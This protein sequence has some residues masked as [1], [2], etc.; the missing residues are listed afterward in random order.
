MKRREFVKI[1]PALPGLALACARG[2]S[3]ARGR[4]ASTRRVRPGDPAWPSPDDWDA[5]RRA[6]GGRLTRPESPFVRCGDA[7]SDACREVVGRLRNPYYIGDQAGLTQTSGWADAWRSQPSAYAIAAESTADVVAAV[8]FAREHNLRLVVKGGG[9]SYKGTSSAPDSLLIWTRR[10]NRVV[11]REDF[12]GVGCA[13]AGRVE[14][15]V[16]VEA[17]AMWMPVYQAVSVEAGRYVQGGGCATVG[18]AGLIQSGG[19]GSFSKA[20]GLAATGLLEA[21]VV[22][23][24]GV[25]RIA[26][27]CTHPDLFWA[28]KGGGGGSL[29]VVTKVTLRTHDLPSY[30]GGAFGVIAASSDDAFR[31]LI[32]H[33]VAFYR[34]HLFSPTWGE[35]LVFGPRNRLRI[36]MV[37]QGIDQAAA[38]RVWQQ[39]R[40]WLERSPGKFS[41]EEP[42][43][44][45]AVPA[46]HFW[47]A[48]FLE[49]NAPGFVVADDRP[50]AN[51]HHVFWA[52]DQG[53]AGQFLHAYRTAWLPASLLESDM[54][55]RL[56]D[57]LFAC[58]R[59][60]PVSLH[61]NKGLAGA[62]PS[63]L[64]AAR[65]TAMNPAVVDAFALA[66]IAGGGPPAYPGMPG[67]EPNLEMARRN[68]RAIHSAMDELL[69]VAPTGGSYLSESDYF[70]SNWAQAFWGSNYPRLE[71]VKRKYDPSGLFIVH[72]GV[73]SDDWSPDG[74]TRKS[75]SET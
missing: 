5:L 15:A 48:A 44:V 49:A 43:T 16:T 19:F 67:S 6:V 24:D 32:A 57:A 1:A 71:A 33:A 51:P 70:E 55:P 50:G 28:L 31:E 30:F 26:N 2:T 34:E 10:M 66:I 9:H 56:V 61:F 53:E 46:R 13:P 40:A 38:E 29:G 39:F 59:R 36:S 63:V 68:S 52:G 69:R 35:Q 65:D 75:T 74:F 27:A 64:T 3:A 62:P 45:L 8:D 58:T 73:G 12:V 41:V 17:G 37:F 4:L 18:V 54:Q 14:R 21:E 60:W 7:G 23:A 25:V 47:D 72:H 20:F 42:L 22:T 11:M